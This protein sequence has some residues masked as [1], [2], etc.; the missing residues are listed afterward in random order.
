MRHAC[1][2]DRALPDSRLAV[3]DGQPGRHQ[4]GLD[5][6]PL[7]LPAEEEEHIEVGVLERRQ[8]LVGREDVEVDHDDSSAVDPAL[9]PGDVLVEG[10]VEE[11]DSPLAPELLLDRL[12]LRPDRPRSVADR[13]RPQTR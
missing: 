5:E 9:Q 3:E 7:A 13:S 2:Q 6:L 11:V 12:G 10:Q 1:S 4:V 8:P